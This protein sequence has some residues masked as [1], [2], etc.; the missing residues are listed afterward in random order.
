MGDGARERTG[1]GER[2]GERA[3]QRERAQEVKLIVSILTI[4]VYKYEVYIETD[5]V[6]QP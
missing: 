1:K 6:F 4:F 5:R 3:R 2:M